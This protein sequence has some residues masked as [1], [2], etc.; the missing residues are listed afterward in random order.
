VW[1]FVT[2]ATWK[3]IQKACGKFRCDSQELR[4]KHPGLKIL[5]VLLVD[6]PNS[7]LGSSRKMVWS[8]N[9]RQSQ[10]GAPLKKAQGGR[11]GEMQEIK[12]VWCWQMQRQSVKNGGP[13]CNPSYSGG[14][15]QED[16]RSK[17]AW[18]NSL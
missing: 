3:L 17:P 1:R 6:G 18:A 16:Q 4:R 11:P 9:R 13:P 10:K 5:T 7:G 2:A 14:K 12:E 8:E 15:D